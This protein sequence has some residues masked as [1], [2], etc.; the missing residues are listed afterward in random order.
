MGCADFEGGVDVTVH[1]V[2]RKVVFAEGD[3]DSIVQR[4]IVAEGGETD[5]IAVGR[6]HLVGGINAGVVG[7]VGREV[8][9][10]AREGTHAE[11]VGGVQVGDGWVRTAAPAYAAGGYCRAAFGRNLSAEG[12]GS[13]GNVGGGGHNGGYIA[14]AGG[15][16]AVD[17]VGEIHIP[18]GAVAPLMLAAIHLDKDGLR[19]EGAIAV[20]EFLE[21]PAVVAD[22]G[23][24]GVDGGVGALVVA[25][26]ERDGG[27]HAESDIHIDNV[28]EIAIVVGHDA[29]GGAVEVHHAHVADGREGGDFVADGAANR[30]DGLDAVAV[31]N[32]HPV[33]HEASHRNTRAENIALVNVVMGDEAVEDGH[34]QAG[35]VPSRAG[36][37]SISGHN[38]TH[39]RVPGIHGNGRVYH[40]KGVG[41]C[42][43]GDGDPSLFGGDAVEVGIVQNFVHVAAQSVKDEDHRCRCAGIIGFRHVF[44]I[45][46]GG[47]LPADGLEGLGNRG[48]ADAYGHQKCDGFFHCRIVD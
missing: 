3:F 22:V 42:L 6:S 13:G 21:Q 41:Q 43:R 36:H 31:L 23:E 24:D 46:A 9:D 48:E 35:V 28:L 38:G 17:L 27:V 45:L 5:F 18:I 8:G 37:D 34:H 4:G 14:Q 2:V 20:V 25:A 26:P 19:A 7:G 40:G 30:C 11:R 15:E 32:R 16:E 10:G 33:R 1:V 12:G 29:V 44:Q 39:T 47:V